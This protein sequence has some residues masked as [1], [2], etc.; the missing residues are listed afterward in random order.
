MSFS[1]EGVLA[2]A[3]LEAARREGEVDASRRDG[4]LRADA[5]PAPV[6]RAA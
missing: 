5:L 1:P 6:R 3:A 2:L 4:A